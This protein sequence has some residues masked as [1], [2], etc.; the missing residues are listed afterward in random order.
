[1]QRLIAIAR[2]RGVRRLVGVILSENVPML[3]LVQRLGFQITATGETSRATL[4]V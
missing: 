4:E 2:Q 1:M 3:Q